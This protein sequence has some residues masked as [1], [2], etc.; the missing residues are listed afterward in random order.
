NRA[1]VTLSPTGPAGISD[2]GYRGAPI[3]SVPAHPAFPSPSSAPSSRTRGAWGSRRRRETIHEQTDLGRGAGGGAQ[4]LYRG[5]GA[6][7]ECGAVR[8]RGRARG[9]EAEDARGRARRHGDRNELAQDRPRPVAGGRERIGGL[10]ESARRAESRQAGDRQIPTG[11]ELS[12]GPARDLRQRRGAGRVRRR[13][14][15]AKDAEPDRLSAPTLAA[16]EAG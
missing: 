12:R 2:R 3:R 6:R 8:G 13:R 15:R 1:L 9:A 10:E 7:A 5:S 14:L 11:R 16:A 4:R